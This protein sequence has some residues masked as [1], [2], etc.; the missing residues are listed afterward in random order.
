MRGT[1]EAKV[2]VRQEARAT[3][4]EAEVV[5]RG[6]P[7]QDRGP[8]PGLPDAVVPAVEIG[9]ALDPVPAIAGAQA[10][11][12]TDTAAVAAADTVVVVEVADSE[13]GEEAVLAV[14][15]ADLVAVV[16]GRGRL[17]GL[18]DVVD[19]METEK[20]P[21]NPKYWASSIS[22]SDPERKPYKMCSVGTDTS[23]R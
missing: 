12:A 17:L 11:T 19:T 21:Q 14:A 5:P 22:V 7:D 3:R 4:V 18:E 8:S 16:A 13:A 15:A 20:L 1:Q 2:A 10:A 9:V 23:R 6:T